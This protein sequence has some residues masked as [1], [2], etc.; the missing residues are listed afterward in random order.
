MAIY[1]LDDLRAAAPAELKNLSDED[2]VRDF[3]YRKGVPF[4]QEA[5]YF[6]IKPR[7]LFGAMATQAAGGAV[8]DLPRMVGQA[9]QYLGADE[10]GRGLIEGAEQ[11]ERFYTPDMRNRNVV[12]EALTLGARALAP[13]AATLPLGLVPG[14]Q[15][16]APAAAAGLFGLSSAQETYQKLLDQGVSEPEARAASYR[17]G[18]IQGLGE[19]AATYTG[20]KLLRPA[21]AAVRGAPTTARIAAEATETGIA[22]PFA[23]GMLTNLAVQPTTEVAQDLGTAYTEEAY[24]A[25]PE[26]KWEI[27]RQSALGGAGLTLL[28]GPLALGGAVRR[29]QNAARLK[30]ALDP[31]SKVRPEDRYAAMD[32]VMAEARRQGVAET[33]VGGWLDQ[34]LM[35]E[36]ARTAELQRQEQAAFRQRV[37]ER[38]AAGEP[39][40]MAVS[41]TEQEAQNPEFWRA[42]ERRLGIAPE[43]PQPVGLR[44]QQAE[45]GFDLLRAPQVPGIAEVQPGIFMELPPLEQP[46]A[47]PAQP[48]DLTQPTTLTTSQ[49]MLEEQEGGEPVGIPVA[50]PSA[51]S[52]SGVSAPTLPAPT[53]QTLA[54]EEV[55]GAPPEAPPV[56]PAATRPVEIRRSETPTLNVVAYDA[57][58]KDGTPAELVVQRNKKTN[59]VQGVYASTPGGKKRIATLSA[60]QR[61]AVPPTAS[62]SEVLA[63]AF[64]GQFQLRIP[65]TPPAGAEALAQTPAAL[66]Q[67]GAPGTIAVQ[68]VADQTASL[69]GVSPVAAGLPPAPVAGGLSTQDLGTSK[70]TEAP[71]A[72]KAPKAAAPT[73]PVVETRQTVADAIKEDVADEAALKAIEAEDAK[74][75]AAIKAG[76]QAPQQDLFAATQGK[77]AKPAGKTSLPQMV[78]AAIRNTLLNPDRPV[79]VYKPKSPDIDKEATA[80]YGERVR[81]IATA[82]QNFADAYETYVG[83]TQ[84]KSDIVLKKGVTAEQRMRN[85]GDLG[86]TRAVEVRNALAALG[87]AVGGNAKDVE[88]VV[89]LVKDRVQAKLSKDPLH[90]KLD[91]RLSSAWA[92][93]KRETFMQEPDKLDVSQG[94]SRPSWESEKRGAT[95][96]LKEAVIEGYTLYGKGAKKKGFQGLL[97]FLRTGGT[98]YE[99]SLATALSVATEGKMDVQVEFIDEGTPRFDPAKNTIYIRSAESREVAL[100]EALHA[101]LQWY[102]Y[103]NPKAP[104]VVALQKAVD[105]VVAYDAAKLPPKAAEV[106]RILAKLMKDNRPLDAVLELISYGNTLNEFRR[107]LQQMESQTPRTFRKFAND[108]LDAIRALFSRFLGNRRS[109]ANDVLENTFELLDAAAAT[110]QT[111]AAQA[112]AAKGATLEAAVVA[113]AS[114]PESDSSKVNLTKYKE[115]PGWKINLTRMVFERMGF[116]EGG[117]R[118]KEWSAKYDKV[119]ADLTR[120]YPDLAKNLRTIAGSFGLG[121]EYRMAKQ[122]AKQEKQTGVVETEKL[123]EQVYRHNKEALRIFQYLDGDEAVLGKTGRDAVLRDQADAIRELLDSYI[124]AIPNEKDRRLFE[125][126]SFTDKLLMPKSIGDLAKKSFGMHSVSALFRPEIR[127][128]KTLDEFKALLPMTNNVVDSDVPLYQIF[129]TR[130]EFGRMPVGFVSEAQAN[131]HPELDIDRS[132]VWYADGSDKE[133]FRFRT[134]NISGKNL[135]DVARRLGDPKVPTQEKEEAVQQLSAALMTTMAALSHNASTGNF[136][137]TLKATGRDK[138]GKATETT[139]AFDSVDEVNEVFPSRKLTEAGLEQATDDESRIAAIRSITRRGDVWVRLPDTDGYGELR[140]KIVP[141]GLYSDI[142]DMHDRAPVINARTLNE[143]ITAFKKSKT[144]FSPAT[145]VNNVLTNYALMLL[146]GIPHRALGDAARLIW[147]YELQPDSLTQEQRNIMKA[148]YKSGA[149][150]GQF[151]NAEAKSYLAR[152]MEQSITQKSERSVLTKLT[153]WLKFEKDFSEYAAELSRKGKLT[154]TTISEVYAAGDNVFRLAAFLNVAG[155]LQAKNSGQMTEDI[156]KQSGLRAREMFLDYDI[157][158]R[159]VRAA[160]QSVLPFVSWSYAITPLLGRLAITRPWA[161]V[162]MMAALYA[163][164]AMGDDDE[165][166]KEGPK[167]VRE[168]SLWGMGPYNMVR[169]PFIGTEDQ[170]Y[171]Y[172]IGKS[173]P[174]MSLF[175]PP[176]GQGKLFGFEA[177]PG[178]ITPNGPYVTLLANIFGN[179]PF[180]GKRLYTDAN[181]SF[182]KFKNVAAT[183]WDSLIPPLVANRFWENVGKLTDEKAGPTGRAPDML[184]IARMLGLSAYQYDSEETKFYQDAAVKKLQR[185]FKMMMNKAKRDEEAKGYPD[186]AALDEQL[187]ELQGRMEKRVAELR[188]QEET[189]DIE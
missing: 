148:F 57:T 100:H 31:A 189:E 81:N 122:V 67:E 114:T 97:N 177:I 139:L 46:T 155:T 92:A 93:A 2:L 166:R 120:K 16:A 110:E 156:L 69:P 187:M 112:T 138:N 63:Q 82:L 130:G 188:G 62:D 39:P 101:A 25:T 176:M 35:A 59:A 131:A 186:Y 127:H 23:R 96:P 181:T 103:S 58:S 73:A 19:A 134:R 150:L 168:R 65:V 132:R 37:E 167:E 56:T 126:L 108:V 184:F 140:N 42:F 94:P 64:P 149:V 76:K 15:F 51:V 165:W 158:S 21:M 49:A 159:L 29:S 117:K 145:H 129:E 34:Q 24:G 169:I 27:A 9:A 52:V 125:G 22:R 1:T 137:R 162:N 80:T 183:V 174:L 88:A 141:G 33:D 79:K 135:L 152:K 40:E 111:Q 143:M 84:V 118:D 105:A 146:H 48:I 10:F 36:D 115:G 173:I 61:K 124:A 95:P 20:A 91:I 13:V 47:P 75:E 99:K 160:R 142:L 71:K 66:P 157:D 151:T 14:G 83:R 147:R 106:Q 4:E 175:E 72:P 109:L 7:G 32:A 89:R 172:N 54:E 144:I 113:E 87:E 55:A 185:E 26:D 30:E 104:Q 17:V 38:I 41:A 178:A 123:L 11:R 86:E 12:G 154:E 43:G 107:A 136:F 8:V 18:A 163:M 50:Q 170:P 121:S 179:D 153:G 28:L 74:L 78:L 161:M 102:V 164:G 90:E 3:S 77:T 133:G 171:Y 85:M 128:E 45:E 60:E 98:P 119:A 6:G 68:S 182:E 53:I 70:P 5:E 116:G 44:R 180:T